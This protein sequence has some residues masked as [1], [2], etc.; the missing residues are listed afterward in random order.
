M[1]ALFVF[2]ALSVILTPHF[3]FSQN[4]IKNYEPPEVTKGSDLNVSFNSSFSSFKSIYSGNTQTGGH[5]NFNGSYDCWK[6]TDRLNYAVN[7]SSEIYFD[8]SNST[9]VIIDVD[10]SEEQ[11]YLNSSNYLRAGASYYFLKN[12][13]YGGLFTQAN[14]YFANKTNPSYYADFFPSVG[15]GK[16]V[17]AAEV[18]DA[19]NFEKVLIKQKVISKP[20]SSGVKKKLIEL[21]DRRNNSE[22]YSKYKDDAEIEFYSQV[23][24]LLTDEG[25][26][27][28]PLSSRTTLKLFQTLSNSKFIFYPKYKGYQIQAELDYTMDNNSGYDAVQTGYIKSA[29]L[30]AIY[31]LPINAKLSLLG[32]AFFT[33]PVKYNYLND[34]DYYTF[35]SPISLVQ[36][37]Q[38][39]NYDN[40]LVPFFKGSKGSENF[41]Y[42]MS[43]ALDAYYNISSV[44]GANFHGQLNL[45]KFTGSASNALASYEIRAELDYN[46]LSKMIL[47]LSANYDKSFY[48]G[49]DFGGAFRINYIIF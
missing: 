43:G 21:L 40:E 12:K 38:R 24:R 3:L 17:D 39:P 4:E 16:L 7:V 49:Y 45:A 36:Y 5:L 33:V 27:N 2:V 26:I 23:E 18:T 44:A 9:E 8:K 6:L 31:G 48:S 11:V 19:D 1:K 10:I 25:V 46:I 20:L 22:F 34:Y 41:S 37:F 32:A 47:E 14:A 28:S 15:F 35:H 29:T 42:K 30:S 13:F